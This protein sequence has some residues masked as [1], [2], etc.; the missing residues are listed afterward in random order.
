MIGVK[1]PAE[2]DAMINTKSRKEMGLP[3]MS[4]YLKLMKESRAKSRAQEPKRP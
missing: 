2:R 1:Q 4:D 3:P